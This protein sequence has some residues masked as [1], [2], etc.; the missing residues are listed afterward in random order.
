MNR[1][2]FPFAILVFLL[3][4]TS[5]SAAPVITGKM[6]ALSSQEQQTLARLDVKRWQTELFVE[7]VSP[8]LDHLFHHLQSR[9]PLNPIVVSLFSTNFQGQSIQHIDNQPP[10]QKRFLK[11]ETFTF[12]SQWESLT[13]FW[14][15]IQQ[16]LQEQLIISHTDYHIDF[17][18]IT[19]VGEKTN[20][21]IGMDIHLNGQDAL[22][23]K[24]V[25][26]YWEV[27]FVKTPNS[28]WKI[29]R[30]HFKNHKIV[31]GKQVFTNV[32]TFLPKSAFEIDPETIGDVTIAHAGNGISL[33]DWDDDGDLDLFLGRPK[34]PP[35]FYQNDGVGGFKDISRQM[36]KLFMYAP[37]ESTAG[38]FFDADNDGDLDFLHLKPRR[39]LFFEKQGQKF[40]EKTRQS[41]LDRLPRGLWFSVAFADYNLDGMLDLYLTRYGEFQNR[42]VDYFNASGEPNVLL[43]NRGQLQFEDVT[44]Q[45]GL[46]THNRQF[47]YAA[48]W[49]DFNRDGYPD[50]YVANDF[51]G[52]ALY[53]NLKNGRFQET[54]SALTAS[55]PGNGMGVSWLDYNNDGYP[56]LYI[57]NMR[58]YAG[59]RITHNEHF[60][61]NPELVKL[62]QR[63][64]KGN[65]LLSNV[66]GTS[67]QEVSRQTTVENAGWA[68]GSAVFDY[69]LDGNEDIYVANGF[70]SNSDSG[71]T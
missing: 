17:A 1:I 22:Q 29:D 27:D 11:I 3:W 58:S 14:K 18:N 68:W 66:N 23:K 2:S 8:L 21:K 67:F 49:N 20:F 28:D 60:R 63:F 24:M 30:I 31:S 40:V 19:Q 33:A 37:K 32:T 39:I 57:S 7:Q 71:D 61:G 34:L 51:G 70:F 52:N 25:E 64:A 59:T 62:A 13:T 43:K 45:S 10:L 5:L 65:T 50:L 9:H 55:D 12:T 47:S 53:T 54:T 35:V 48:A 41:G 4:T 6:Q 36:R 38:Y 69:D 44:V 46:D 42:P 15:G 16:H 26:G 56:D